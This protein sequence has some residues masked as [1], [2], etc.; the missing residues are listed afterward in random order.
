MLDPARV[1]CLTML[2]P[3]C[4]G[5]G[6][7]MLDP[8]CTRRAYAAT[9]RSPRK[10]SA[11]HS[12]GGAAPRSATLRSGAAKQQPRNRGRRRRAARRPSLLASPQDDAT[13]GA[14]L[15]SAGQ[16][17]EQPGVRATETTGYITDAHLHCALH[18]N[19]PVCAARFT[20][21]Q[22][23]YKRKVFFKGYRTEAYPNGLSPRPAVHQRPVSAAR[24]RCCFT[25][26]R[27]LSTPLRGCQHL[28]APRYT[29]TAVPAS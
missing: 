14:R 12:C 1:K 19:R 15:R 24:C 22:R 7:R 11:D 28:S 25:A 2:N 16:P 18:R 6:S 13:S 20:V 10:A 5:S 4:T 26:A 27:R 23:G 29:L 9:L 3:G 21:A 17:Q 8:C